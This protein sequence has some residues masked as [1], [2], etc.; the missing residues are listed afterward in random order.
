MDLLIGFTNSITP[1]NAAISALAV[2]IARSPVLL[3]IFT[4]TG[5]T[6]ARVYSRVRAPAPRLPAIADFV[7]NQEDGPPPAYDEAVAQVERMVITAPLEGFTPSMMRSLVFCDAAGAGLPLGLFGAG[8]VDIE[9]FTILPENDADAIWEQRAASHPEIDPLR[10][11]A[12]E[13]RVVVYT[14]P[15]VC[16][17]LH[18]SIRFVQSE[19]IFGGMTRRRAQQAICELRCNCYMDANISVRIV[20]SKAMLEEILAYSAQLQVDADKRAPQLALMCRRAIPIINEDRGQTLR[21]GHVTFDQAVAV[22]DAVCRRSNAVTG[23]WDFMGASARNDC[24]ALATLTF[25]VIGSGITM[26]V[27]HRCLAPVSG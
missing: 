20:C 24:I 13:N 21:L 16:A 27:F 12:D 15:H 3:C 8:V 5:L 26:W 23:R 14:P 10:R 19:V 25:S 7:A 11:R 22:A 1:A 4:I 9:Q 2:R 18:D 6:F 17:H